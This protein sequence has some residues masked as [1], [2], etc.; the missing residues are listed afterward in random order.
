MKLLSIASDSKT[1]KGEKFGVMTAILYLAPSD[2]SRV[3]DVCPFSSKGCRDA[4]LNTAGRASIFPAILEARVRKTRWFH[5]DRE[6]FIAQL[7]KEIQSF[8]KSANRKG[9]KACVRLNGTSELYVL[10]KRIAPLFL[11]SSFT[12][13]SRALNHGCVP[14]RTIT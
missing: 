6:A 8:V 9:M 13:T 12:I 7:I 4:C 11:I 1:V 14:C 5:S 3:M 10:A 2:T